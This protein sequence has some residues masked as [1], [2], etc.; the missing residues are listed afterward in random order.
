[1][2]TDTGII[3]TQ[4]GS[5]SLHSTSFD[6]AYHSHYGAIQES[7]HVFL[8]AGLEHILLNHEVIRVFEMGFGTGLNALLTWLAADKWSKS[9]DYE[10]VELAPISRTQASQLNYPEIL[11]TPPDKFLQLHEKSWNQTHLLSPFFS[12]KKIEGKL[13]DIEIGSDFNVVYYDA[14]APGTQP[15]LW[16]A[17]VFDKIYQAMSPESVLVTY[18]AKGVVKRCLKSIG[19][20]VEGIPGP[21]GKREMTRA[22]KPT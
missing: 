10:S 21:P 6:A 13:Q 16:E 12:F 18:C 2:A 9:I 7:Q 3:E 15:E 8:T 14:F 11:D 22:V 4:D 5:H 1:M 20:Q 17:P 19:F